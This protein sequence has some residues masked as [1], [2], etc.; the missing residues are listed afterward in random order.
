MRVSFTFDINDLYDVVVRS[1]R[2]TLRRPWDGVL[3]Q[4]WSL[5]VA[6]PAMAWLVY[7]FSHDGAYPLV[8]AGAGLTG[9][10][11]Q[12]YTA[13][14]RRTRVFEHLEYTSGGVGPFRCEVE[15][16]ADGIVTRQFD[17]EMRRPWS[18]VQDVRETAVGV[19]VDFGRRGLLVV[20]ANAFGSA[21]DRTSFVQCAR[22]YAQG[23]RRQ[24]GG[25]RPN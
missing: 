8:I 9:G 20:R 6:I 10:L 18:T 3:A 15:L 13:Q 17:E 24:S 2:R 1:S 5:L 14:S 19:E 7:G 25:A 4:L 11:A 16:I 23:A 12:W 21:S 22:E